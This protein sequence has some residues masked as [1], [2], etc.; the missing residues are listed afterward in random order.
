[1]T[2]K[3][4]FLLEKITFLTFD[5]PVR[6]LLLSIEFHY[7]KLFAAFPLSSLFFFSMFSKLNIAMTTFFKIDPP[8]QKILTDEVGF[9]S[10]ISKIVKMW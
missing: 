4:D 6:A 8:S 9:E 5:V 10:S 2:A 7:I 1:M 3:N